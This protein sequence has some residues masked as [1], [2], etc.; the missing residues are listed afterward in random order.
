VLSDRNAKT[1]FA[2][3]DRR[4]I[5]EQLMNVSVT[6]WSYKHQIPSVRHIGPIAQ[7]F[8]SAFGLGQD[9]RYI[10]TVD[11]DGVALASIQ[12]LYEIVQEQERQIKALEAEN[13][14]Q[15]DQLAT[16]EARLTALEQTGAPGTLP[17]PSQH[18]PV[19]W[20]TLV[21]ISLVALAARICRTLRGCR[22]SG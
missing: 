22:Q 2:S 10:S 4:D 13:T 11:T 19:N 16:L 15:L 17:S 5:L 8:Y 1:G 7:D 3:V 6:T 21:V 14:A 12:G 20:S 9:N 18:L